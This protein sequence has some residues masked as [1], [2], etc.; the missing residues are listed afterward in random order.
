[1]KEIVWCFMYVKATTLTRNHKAGRIMEKEKPTFEENI[2]GKIII[3]PKNY[4]SRNQKK[5]EI[6]K[7]YISYAR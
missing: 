5:D 2:Q 6:K 3:K 1:M 4:I 7:Y